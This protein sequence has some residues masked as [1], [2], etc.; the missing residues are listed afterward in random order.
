MLSLDIDNVYDRTDRQW[1]HWS[2]K[3]APRAL[4]CRSLLDGRSV[5]SGSL[6]GPWPWCRPSPW[7]V[8]GFAV[9]GVQWL[10]WRNSLGGCSCIPF[11]L[12]CIGAWRMECIPWGARPTMSVCT[13]ITQA[14]THLVVDGGRGWEAFQVSQGLKGSRF[15]PHLFLLCL[16]V[17]CCVCVCC[18]CKARVEGPKSAGEV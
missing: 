15:K 10:G 11:M 7:L 18:R 12:L 2:T 3:W 16:C 13:C 4:R 17:C 5:G 14:C 1:T 6:R 9:R 8:T